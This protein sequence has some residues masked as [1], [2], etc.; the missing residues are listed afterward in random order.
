MPSGFVVPLQL[1]SD[2]TFLVTDDPA[3][4][5]RQ[6]ILDLLVTN[7]Y[8][9]VMRPTY[10]CDLEGFLFT[11]VIEHLLAAKASEITSIINNALSYGEVLDTRITPLPDGPESVVQVQVLYRAY[12]GGGVEMLSEQLSASDLAIEGM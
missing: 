6:R 7:L 2:G 3:R 5:L 1:R 4:I 9:R 12:L 8:E 10:G 11:E